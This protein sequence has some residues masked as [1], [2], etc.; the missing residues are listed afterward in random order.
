MYTGKSDLE[1]VV[2]ISTVPESLC[3][4]TVHPGD[5]AVDSR[6]LRDDLAPTSNCATELPGAN[7]TWC[8]I[9]DN[10]LYKEERGVGG[11]DIAKV[12]STSKFESSFGVKRV[13]CAAM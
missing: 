6:G 10:S 3:L 5:M 12:L 13:T 8:Q 2:P 7:T 11:G 9:W 4:T 1:N